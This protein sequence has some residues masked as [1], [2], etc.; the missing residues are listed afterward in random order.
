M[1]EIQLSLHSNRSYETS[2]RKI[3]DLKIRR[4]QQQRMTSKKKK[5]E[6]KQS[7]VLAPFTRIGAFLKPHILLS[8]LALTET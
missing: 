8:R 3:R 6:K 1:I 2:S 4:W 5:K 7:Q